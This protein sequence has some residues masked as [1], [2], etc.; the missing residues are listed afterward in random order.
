M[1]EAN[2]ITL[3]QTFSLGHSKK[4]MANNLCNVLRRKL[5]GV[6]R[7]QHWVK[8]PTTT[9]T[10]ESRLWGKTVRAGKPGLI[11]EAVQHVGYDFGLETQRPRFLNQANAIIQAFSLPQTDL[12]HRLL[13]LKLGKVPWML[14]WIISWKVGYNLRRKNLKIFGSL[15]PLLQLGIS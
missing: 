14:I 8:V 11:W 4:T 5:Q 7:K 13:W 1:H 10:K 12:P 15:F 9:T 2:C 3:G 6:V